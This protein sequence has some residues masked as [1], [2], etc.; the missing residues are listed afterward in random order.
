VKY[1]HNNW[2][3]KRGQANPCTSLCPVRVVEHIFGFHDGRQRGL[4]RS[5]HNVLLRGRCCTERGYLAQSGFVDADDSRRER[6]GEVLLE[7][8]V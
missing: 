8:I 7:D 1:S 5:E 6:N 2:Y 3:I 4:V